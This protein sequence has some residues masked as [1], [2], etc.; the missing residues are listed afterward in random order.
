VNSIRFS[1]DG[2]SLLTAGDRG[3][4]VVWSVPMGKRGGGN[5]RYWWGEVKTEADLQ[6]KVVRT[7]CEVRFNEDRSDSSAEEQSENRTTTAPL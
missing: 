2:L 5:G 7:Q 4:V 6:C 1:P 3:A